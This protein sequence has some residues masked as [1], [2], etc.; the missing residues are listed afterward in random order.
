VYPLAT[1]TY[2]VTFTIY[3]SG[4]TASEVTSIVLT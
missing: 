3:G 4:G 1:G 2:T